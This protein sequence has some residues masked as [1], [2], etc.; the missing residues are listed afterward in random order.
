MVATL[1]VRVESQKI[2]SSEEWVA[3]LRCALIWTKRSLVEWV[4]C[5]DRGPS[6]VMSY[7]R[8]TLAV[9]TLTLITRGYSQFLTDCPP[10]FISVRMILQ[11]LTQEKAPK[12]Y[13]TGEGFEVNFVP[14]II[15]FLFGLQGCCHENFH[16]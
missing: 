10:L 13:L 9:L 12:F 8:R 16:F 15:L 1:L 5:E 2:Y 11:N 7:D 4:L 3:R 14:H 6:H